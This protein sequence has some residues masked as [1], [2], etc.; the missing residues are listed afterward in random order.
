W[1]QQRRVKHVGTVGSGNH[2]DAVVH[3]E[4]VHLHQQLV[5]GLFT[6]I[7]T[8]AKPGAAMATDGIDLV[9]EN[10]AGRMLHGL[11]EHVAHAA[12]NHTHKHHYEV[13]TGN[14]EERHLGLTRNGLGQQCLTGTR[15]TDHQHT[16]R[17]TTAEALEL[18]RITQKLDE[19]SHFFL[20]FVTTGHIGKGG[21]DL[22]FREQA[23]LAFAEA[24]WPT[25]AACTALHLAHEEH[26]HRDDHQNREAG[27][28]QLGPAALLFGLLAFDQHVVVE[29]IANQAVVL[30]RRTDRL[31]AFAIA[32]L[33]DDHVAVDGHTLDATFLDLFKELR[34]VERLWF[35]RTGKIVH[36]SH[37]HG[38]DDQPQ[39]QV[40]CHV[41][42]IHYPLERPAVVGPHRGLVGCSG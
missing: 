40:F 15:G 39:N 30:N 12:R 26:E 22:I 16:A 35:A 8:T 21:L 34:I 6:L 4:T 3:F 23:R 11:L 41:I 38:G 24:H 32:A 29:Q 14:G 20:G 33:A 7:M 27:N 17:N 10:D 9:N 28:P 36:H 18:A 25:L 19:F 5:E 2:D 1:T 37:Q 13:G 31:E 42:Q